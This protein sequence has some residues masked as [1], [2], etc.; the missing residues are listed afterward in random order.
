MFTSPTLLKWRYENIC[1]IYWQLLPQ[2]SNT[3]RFHGLA[4]FRPF[5]SFGIESSEHNERQG[6]ICRIPELKMR[7][8]ASI[9]TLR[10]NSFHIHRPKVFN[11]LPNEL[12]S[13]KNCSVDEFKSELDKILQLIPDEPNVNGL[14]TPS[15]CDMFTGKPSNSIVD[16]IRSAHIPLKP[17]RRVGS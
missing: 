3:F 11:C 1:N 7:A 4:E 14:Y 12:R 2:F 6:R 9:K 16:Q 17:K 8:P 10:D 5:S 13:M 15:A